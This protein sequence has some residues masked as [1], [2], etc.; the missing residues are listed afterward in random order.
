M[1]TE[2]TRHVTIRGLVQGVGF[3]HY[4]RREALRLGVAG[5]V[6]NRHDGSVEAVVHGSC[7]AVDAL[8]GWAQ[9]GPPSARVTDVQ[10]TEESGTF[11]GFE[12]RPTA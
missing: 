8:I 1:S 3:R 7:D 2:I 10:V 11:E 9:H 12:Q 4:M 6:R 5:W